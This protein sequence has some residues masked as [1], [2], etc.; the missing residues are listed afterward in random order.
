PAEAAYR[1]GLL[2]RV[3]DIVR[4]A[5]ETRLLLPARSFDQRIF[6]HCVEQTRAEDRGG[7]ARRRH[8][9]RSDCSEGQIGESEPWSAQGHSGSVCQSFLM[10]APCDE[11]ISFR[12]HAAQ[13]ALILQLIA[14]TGM[15]QWTAVLVLS[16]NRESYHHRNERFFCGFR[17]AATPIAGMTVDTD[18]A[19]GGWTAPPFTPDHRQNHPALVKFLSAICEALELRRVQRGSWQRISQRRFLGHG[20]STTRQRRNW[21]FG[22]KGQCGAGNERCTRQRNQAANQKCISRTLRKSFLPS[23]ASEGKDSRRSPRSRKD[24]QRVIIR[25]MRNCE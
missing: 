12:E 17:G 1:R 15:R 5:V 25:P 19:V 4:L 2:F 8:D 23:V 21:C 11:G 3:P 6:R 9:V 7:D 16:G 24:L 14:V 20:K 22:G 13:F 18:F 10:L